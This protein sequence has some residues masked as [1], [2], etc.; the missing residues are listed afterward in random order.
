MEAGR[1]FGSSRIQ[2][3]TKVQ[4]PLAVP[5][6]MAGIN[7]TAMVGAG[8]LGRDVLL[9]MGPLENGDAFIAGVAIVILA[10]IVDRI[11]QGYISS[12]S[13]STE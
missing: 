1:A 13:R 6:I 8:G 11:S 12:R 9:A 2:L 7:Q 3:L 5:T 4:I 10:I